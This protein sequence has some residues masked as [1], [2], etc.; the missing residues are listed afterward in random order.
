LPRDQALPGTQRLAFPVCAWRGIVTEIHHLYAGL[1]VGPVN[2]AAQLSRDL[3]A[4]LQAA[5]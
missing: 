1:N 4:P 5:F 2:G 3:V